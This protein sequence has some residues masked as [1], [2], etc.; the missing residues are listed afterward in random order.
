MKVTLP[1][2][3]CPFTLPGCA[4]EKFRVNCCDALGASVRG[5][6]GG[7]VREKP[8]PVTEIPR[9]CPAPA[10]LLA[11][12]MV[13]LEDCPTLVL[14][15]EIV[16]PATKADVPAAVVT[17]YVYCGPMPCATRLM[18]KGCPFTVAVNVAA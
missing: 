14:A 18:V 5:K 6:S 16:P 4:G 10:P 12:E 2:V 3:N 15:R 8:W 7:L 11:I 9:I 13:M 17:A 1:I